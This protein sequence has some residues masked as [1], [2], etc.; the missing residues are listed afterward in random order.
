MLNLPQKIHI[1]NYVWYGTVEEGLIPFNLSVFYNIMVVI[2]F[3]RSVVK[4]KSSVECVEPAF[5]NYVSTTIEEMLAISSGAP[6]IMSAIF[7]RTLVIP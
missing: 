3:Y 2:Q 7:S 4:V 1:N 6:T 5:L